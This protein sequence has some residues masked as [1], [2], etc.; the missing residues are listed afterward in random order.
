MPDPR[1]DPPAFERQ[2]QP[3]AK[4]VFT[5]IARQELQH[6]ADTSERARAYAERGKPD[7]TLAFLLASALADDERRALFARAYEQRAA[8]TER[9]AQE[10][11]RQFHRPFPLLFSE[12][13][14]DRAIAR[15]IRAGL[16][17]RPGTGRQLPMR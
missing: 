14:R 16:E 6:G 3:L 5:E 7:F 15:R 1:S 10:F 13:A 4:A 11:D 12:A 2:Y 9:R 8:I 17:V